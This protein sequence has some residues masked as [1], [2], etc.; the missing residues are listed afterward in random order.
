[1]GINEVESVNAEN[2]FKMMHA[3]PF[4]IWPLPFSIL[5]SPTVLT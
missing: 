5:P 4:F 1:M 3:K 2:F